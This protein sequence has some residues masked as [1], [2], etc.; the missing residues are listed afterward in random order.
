VNLNPQQA[1]EK[2]ATLHKL[3]H[4]AGRDP[5][6][7]DISISPYRYRIAVD[8][9]RRYHDLGVNEF[10]PFVQLQRSDE[11]IPKFLEGVAR[12]WVEPAS[13]LE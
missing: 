4:G 1:Q 13:R 10:V 7:L 5:R 3:M 12:E 6:E 2:I 8:D 9:L 11:E